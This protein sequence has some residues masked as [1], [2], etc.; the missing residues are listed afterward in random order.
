MQAVLLGAVV[1][2]DWITQGVPSKSR[3]ETWSLP[4]PDGSEAG[5]GVSSLAG[6]GRYLYAHGTFG[7][8][9][10]G[11]GYSNTKRVRVCKTSPFMGM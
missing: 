4:L 7:L 10:V 2:A 3:I 9:K 5:T 11:T 1:E 8:M 6:D